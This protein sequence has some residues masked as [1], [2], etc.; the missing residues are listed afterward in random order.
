MPAIVPAAAATVDSTA[1]ITETCRGVAPTSRIAANRCSRRAAAS[2]VAVPIRIS[3]GT[4]NAPATIVSTRVMP[5][6]PMPIAQRSQ[7]LGSVVM[8]LDT[9]SAPD[10]P[11]SSSG[12]R[13][14]TISSESGEGSALSPIVPISRPG[15]RSANSGDG[16]DRISSLS[17]GDT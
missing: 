13:P 15:N 8:M 4:I 1:E 5:S 10:I 9:R 2:R 16:F 6:A 11:D 7:S 12:V 3:T 14:T 17:A